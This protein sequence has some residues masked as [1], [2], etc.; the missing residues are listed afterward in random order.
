MNILIVAI[1]TLMVISA[2]GEPADS[3]SM[4]PEPKHLTVRFNISYIPTSSLERENYDVNYDIYDNVFYRG[5]V[6][7][8]ITKIFSLG[9]SLEYLNRHIEPNAIHKRDITGYSFYLDF[10]VNHNFTDSTYNYLV[11][12]LGSGL[13]N[14]HEK[15]GGSATGYSFYGSIGFDLAIGGPI[16]CDLLYRYQLSKITI[17]DWE[18]RYNGSAIQVGL[19]Y[20]IKL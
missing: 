5:E 1:L 17:E 12:G 11:L 15:N 2:Y 3:S 20:R 13:T 16:G 10:K 4:I 18:Y 7:Y 14:L 8:F 6:D 9:G 19:N